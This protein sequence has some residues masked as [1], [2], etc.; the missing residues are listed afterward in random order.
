MAGVPATPRADLPATMRRGRLFAAGDLRIDEVPLPAPGPGET[1]VRMTDMSLCGSDLHWFAEGGIG[2]AVLSEPLVPGHELAGIAVDGPFAG[3]R[4][5]L[6][7]AIPCEACDLCAQGHRNLCPAVRF[8]GHSDTEGGLL[9]YKAWPTHLLHPLPADMTG[10]DGALLEPLGVALHAWDLAHTR[11]GQDIAVVGCGPIGLML[12]QLAVRLGG[13]GKVVAIEPLAHRR[14][15]ALRYGADVAVGP[16]ELAAAS[17]LL[18]RGGAHVVFEVAGTDDAIAE[19]VALA[20]PGARVL[21]A[22]IP[23]D[24]RS[25]FGAGVA[26]R[27]GLT[28]V[29]VRRMKEMYERTIALVASG[30]IDVRGLVTDRLPLEDSAEAFARG[31]QRGGL[32]VVISLG[33]DP[34]PTWTPT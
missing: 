6:D 2:D 1:L 8:S 34:D 29:M 21:L 16:G 25:S 22:G 5:A 4:V 10:A 20:R 7:P 15:A 11:V 28:F 12:V 31:V 33:S 14:E 30:V 23:D 18:S 13:G 19:A 26:R 3:R 27:K 17:E 32:K 24:D 9:E